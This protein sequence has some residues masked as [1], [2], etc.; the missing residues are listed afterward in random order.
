M[1]Q[2]G[3]T[4]FSI[5]RCAY[6]AYLAQEEGKT[7][8]I[9]HSSTFPQILRALRWMALAAA[10]GAAMGIMATFTGLGR[11][12]GVPALAILVCGCSLV[13]KNDVFRRVAGASEAAFWILT[14]RCG[15]T[16]YIETIDST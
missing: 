5:S 13:V 16:K 15:T 11:P 8:L 3:T 2:H 10:V 4:S 1:E 14:F 7:I 6:E 9:A 12:Y